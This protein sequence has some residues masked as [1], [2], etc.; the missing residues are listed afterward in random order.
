MSE[1]SAGRFTLQLAGVPPVG[2]CLILSLIHQEQLDHYEF[3]LSPEEYIQVLREK[4]SSCLVAQANALLEHLGSTRHELSK[5]ILSESFIGGFEILEALSWS[6]GMGIEVYFPDGRRRI[7]P[8]KADS[9]D[10]YRLYY[11]APYFDSVR[12]V[13]LNNF[14]SIEPLPELQK[15]KVATWNLRGALKV[16]K[17]LIIDLLAKHHQ[18]SIVCVQE[19]HLTANSIETPNYS[20]MLGPQVSGRASRGCGFLVAKDFPFPV[21]FH[22]YSVNICQLTVQLSTESTLILLCVHRFNN[23]HPQSSVE[24]GELNG[25]LR[26]L[27]LKNV[28]VCGDFNAHIGKDTVARDEE[29]IHLVGSQF[30]VNLFL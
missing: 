30:V 21:K 18:L 25:I 9:H 17:R 7:Y 24:A 4:I 8:G 28:L 19:T 22:C 6:R 29:L 1:I 20:W 12:S 10:V 3:R 27:T 15:L 13:Q 5:S 16:D 23:G 2:N 11:Y 26:E 14:N